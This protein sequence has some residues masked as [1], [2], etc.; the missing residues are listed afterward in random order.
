MH[1]I[2]KGWHSFEDAIIT[3]I[4]CLIKHIAINDLT[5]ELPL[6][7]QVG[8]ALEIALKAHRGQRDLDASVTVRSPHIME[9]IAAAAAPTAATTLICENIAR[10]GAKPALVELSCFKSVISDSA[11]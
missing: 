10:A 9:A 3:N 7:E 11:K 5:K 2:E 8:T 1:S 4:Q 6:Q